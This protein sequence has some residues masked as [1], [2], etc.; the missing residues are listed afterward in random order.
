MRR[1]RMKLSACYKSEETKLGI[2]SHLDM[3][4]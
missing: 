3:T 2:K 4:S 1:V